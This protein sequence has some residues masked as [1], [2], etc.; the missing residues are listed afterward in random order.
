MSDPFSIAAMALTIGGKMFG[1]I[2]KNKAGKQ[3]QKALY[4]QAREEEI[5][6]AEQELRIRSAARKS[7]GEQ[8]AAQASNGFQGG[9]GS[10]LDALTESQVNAAL[11][12]LTVRRDVAGKARS[13]RAEGDQRRKEGKNGLIEG[14]LGAA[15]S[16]ASMGSD[17][18]SARAGSSSGGGGSGGS[19]G[20]GGSGGKAQLPSSSG[21][22]PIYGGPS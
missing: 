22:P 4:G 13:L 3:N 8:L 7:I 9:T 20:G 6:G 5:A 17:W 16:A 21:T 18:A 11:D 10:A 2:A 12:A 1:G 15:S 14:L 19:S